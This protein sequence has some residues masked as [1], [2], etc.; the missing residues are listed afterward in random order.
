MGSA[1]TYRRLGVPDLAGIGNIDR[2][3]RIEML[4]VQHGTRLDERT[5]D[6]SAPAWLREGEGEHSVAYQRAECERYLAAGGIA[7]G[8]FAEGRLVGIGVLRPHIRPGIAQLAY[9]HVSR[10]HR[11][12][13]IG[14]HL[15]DELERL[16][17][18]HGDTT[19]VVS[20]TPS[21]NTVRFYR[22]RGYEPT[23]EPLPEL[24]ELEPEDVHMQKRLSE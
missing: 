12:S 6:F 10:E 14:R 2:T 22:G 3:E 19:M 23:S 8:A 20:A 13:G 15:S 7:L 4:Y 1:V 16:A 18:E 24:Y 9:L 17:R 21:L 11:A 5:G